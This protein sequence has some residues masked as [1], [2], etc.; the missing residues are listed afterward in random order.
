MSDY[1]FE[2]FRSIRAPDASDDIDRQVYTVTPVYED[3]EYFVGIDQEGNACFLISTVDSEQGTVSPIRLE[4]LEVQFQAKCRIQEPDNS[5]SVKLLTVLRC[6][7]GDMEVVRYFLLICDTLARTLGHRPKSHSVAKFV[8]R[9]AAIFQ[10]VHS[11]G[12]RVVN[13]LFGELFVIARSRVPCNVLSSWRV[14]GR[15]R[16]DFV[17][18]D[19]RL[20]VKTTSGR[21]RKHTF[22]YEQCNPPCRSTGVA[23]S[24]FVERVARGLTLGGL[25]QRIEHHIGVN[26]EL[27]WKLHEV[28]ADTLGT[29]F[30]AAMACNF[31][32]GVARSSLQFFDVARI[33]AIRGETPED[34]SGIKFE[35]DLS[36]S[37][38]IAYSSSASFHEGLEDFLPR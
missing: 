10:R 30:V 33:P 18:S 5:L 11:P 22:S 26:T 27:A 17:R 34:V 25:I 32:E 13:G 37:T 16:F 6:R 3:L 38:P 31:D 36:T 24:M 14:D 7:S 15:A 1:L 4:Y 12:T 9:I 29:S 20:D 21:I 28:V 8:Y 2:L 35:S 23:V 19:F